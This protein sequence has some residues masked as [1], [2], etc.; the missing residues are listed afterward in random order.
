LLSILEAFISSAQTP[1]NVIQF[2]LVFARLISQGDTVPSYM[3]RKT[4]KLLRQRPELITGDV[5]NKP[6]LEKLMQDWEAVPAADPPITNHASTWQSDFGSILDRKT[7]TD[8]ELKVRDINGKEAMVRV[9]RYLI[10]SQSAI[11][12]LSLHTHTKPAAPPRP[13]SLCSAQSVASMVPEHGHHTK[14]TASHS[15]SLPRAS[16][17][18]KLPQPPDDDGHPV[19]ELIV[20]VPMSIFIKI[21]RYTYTRHFGHLSALEELFIFATAR[22]FG[23]HDH[24]DISQ[25]LFFQVGK[26]KREEIE[27]INSAVR[28]IV[29]SEA[30]ER[31]HDVLA[32]NLGKTNHIV[33]SLADHMRQL[34]RSRAALKPRINADTLAL[35]RRIRALEKK[36]QALEKENAALLSGGTIDGEVER[37]MNEEE[38]EE[39]E[40]DDD[41]D[42][43]D[44]E[45]EPETI[46]EAEEPVTTTTTTTTTST[47]ATI[48]T[49]ERRGPPMRPTSRAR[50]T[51][52]ALASSLPPDSTSPVHSPHPSLH[53]TDT[54]PPSQQSQSPLSQSPDV[55]KKTKGS[56]TTIQLGHRASSKKD[57][58][59][60]TPPTSS[61][62]VSS[63]SGRGLALRGGANGGGSTF[64]RARPATFDS[65]V[66]GG[67][68]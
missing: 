20:P 65:T 41:M 40:L 2:A 62:P 15:P 9:H 5:K 37:C 28:K 8:L 34:A 6:I 19:H 25:L 3:W 64:S 12:Q 49:E 4:Q 14:L 48:P 67:G 38:D 52:R 58:G 57:M 17:S 22:I 30:C 61:S 47:T 59:S 11:G 36:V 54:L 68:Q 21:V 24:V 31:I 13:E 26:Q 50:V 39:E 27:V 53:H 23:F 10:Y 32:L 56:R 60:S 66:P 43:P 35:R 63:G 16:S 18:G 55:G 42:V 29:D 44:V 7:F 46:E 45:V 51:P 1:G 33:R